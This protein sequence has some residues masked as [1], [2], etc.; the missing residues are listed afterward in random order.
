MALARTAAEGVAPVTQIVN[1]ASPLATT[2]CLR[3]ALQDQAGLGGRWPWRFTPSA[4]PSAALIKTIFDNVLRDRTQLKAVAW[5]IIGL[6][7]LERRGCLP[8]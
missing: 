4:R 8:Q 6:N 2:V 1:S 3:P 5:S 7:A